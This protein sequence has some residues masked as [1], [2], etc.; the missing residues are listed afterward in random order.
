[1]HGAFFKTHALEK[2]NYFFPK[3]LAMIT[4]EITRQHCVTLQM[5]SYFVLQIC[6]SIHM[7]LL[8]IH[9]TRAAKINGAFSNNNRKKNHMDHINYCCPMESGLSLL[10]TAWQ[11][12]RLLFWPSS[13][14]FIRGVHKHLIKTVN[15][16]DAT[17]IT[18]IEHTLTWLTY[19]QT[20]TQ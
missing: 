16:R 3:I 8:G 4:D 7:Y 19:G 18:P 20:V 5:Y 14:P 17:I 12:I 15:T 6:V 13:K 10:G 2:E 11:T 9:I 1:M